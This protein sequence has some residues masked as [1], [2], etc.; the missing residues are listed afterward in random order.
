MKLF[1]IE[2]SDEGNRVDLDTILYIGRHSK[3]G[4][5]HL[6][7]IKTHVLGEIEEGEL[8]EDGNPRMT[9]QQREKFWTLC[10]RYNVPFRED[11]YRYMEYRDGISFYE[12][13]IG[14]PGHA[15]GTPGNNKG[16]I[17]VAVE[18]SGISHS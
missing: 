12:G 15:H 4:D 13:W 11:D 8:R 3:M 10:G 14:G 7:K 6:A 2:T 16:T 18:P 5:G 9:F 17:F 1:L